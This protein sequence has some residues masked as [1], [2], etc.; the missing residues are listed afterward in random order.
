MPIQHATPNTVPTHGRY[1]YFVEN[2]S[3]SDEDSAEALIYVSLPI[4]RLGQRITNLRFS[5]E[6]L[7]IVSDEA[8]GN[9]IAIWRR[10]GFRKDETACFHYDFDLEYSSVNCCLDEGTPEACGKGS[11]EYKAYTVSEPWVEISEAIISKAG[12]IAAI[13]PEPLLRVRAIFD[14]VVDNMKYEYP[15]ITLRGAGKSFERMRGDCGEFARVFVALCRAAGIPARTITAKWLEQGG[16]VWTEFYMKPFGWCPADPTLAHLIKFN[17][18]GMNAEWFRK[19]PG[20]D[21]PSPSWLMGN[22]Y[23]KRLI[24]AI[25]DNIRVSSEKLGREKIFSY[26]QPGGVHAYPDGVECCGF[27]RKPVHDGFFLFGGKSSDPLYAA[28][29]AAMELADSYLE[30]KLYDKAE[31]GF[32]KKIEL[33]STN[34]EAWLSLGEVFQLTGRF[35]PAIEAFDKVLAGS[36]GSL[37][38]VWDA[39]AHFH[40][41]NCLDMLSDRAAALE[42]YNL[43]LK[44]GIAYEGLQEKVKQCLASPYVAP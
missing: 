22:L 26:M 8:N 39:V 10:H 3:R 44:S 23:P 2:I 24:I 9:R 18:P 6:P 25:G 32:R 14:W 19:V 28:G 33:K 27:S 34:A 41:G 40:A 17:L 20:M 36:G 5:P 12:E 30:N 7:E 37:K 42:R 35:K 31:A 29:L 13:H 21:L 1:W 16:H 11:E 43:V 4:S 38:P 15:D